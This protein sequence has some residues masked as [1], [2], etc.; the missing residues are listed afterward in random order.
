[1]GLRELAELLG[2]TSKS[3]FCARPLLDAKQV[4]AVD[5][6]E[7]VLLVQWPAF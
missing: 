3:S 4:Y 5:P 1:M 2:I 7:W 6:V